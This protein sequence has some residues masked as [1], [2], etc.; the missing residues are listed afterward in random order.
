M[1]FWTS[2]SLKS[3]THRVQIPRHRRFSIAYF[4]QP[5]PETVTPPIANNSNLQPLKPIQAAQEDG[6]NVI[7]ARQHLFKQ[8]HAAMGKT[9]ATPVM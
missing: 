5:D 6:G 1:Q 7:T 2:Q 3:T 4:V 8:I 9:A